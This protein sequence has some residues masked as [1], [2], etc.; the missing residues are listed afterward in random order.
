MAADSPALLQSPYFDAQLFRSQPSPSSP[1]SPTTQV[2]LHPV[3]ASLDLVTDRISDIF[4]H[5]GKGVEIKMLAVHA[6]KFAREEMVT[7]PSSHEVLLEGLGHAGGQVYNDK[8][9][10]VTIVQLL[11]TVVNC[12]NDP[13]DEYDEDEEAAMYEQDCEPE[14]TELTMYQALMQRNDMAEF[15][16]WQRPLVNK[17]GAV[18]LTAEEIY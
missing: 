2:V 3:F 15:A 16:G 18:V 5:S 8:G 4:L 10:G 11:E 6:L 7:Y 1:L 17:D 9:H 13:S 12:W 14:M